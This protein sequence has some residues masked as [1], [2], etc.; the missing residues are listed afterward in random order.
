M[1]GK[2]KERFV[3]LDGLRGAA[4]FAVVTVHASSPTG[5]A[6]LPEAPLAVDF[7]FAL[8][9]FVLAYAY[10]ARFRN[11]LSVFEFMR[12]RWVRFWPMLLVAFILALAYILIGAA[13]R[14]GFH[15]SLNKYLASIVLGLAFL[16][17]PPGLS[18]DPR[19]AFPIVGPSYTMF[20]E[21]SVN[22]LFALLAA[23]LS[24][25]LLAAIV[26]LFAGLL[27]W[28][29]WEYGTI[30][31]GWLWE[32]FIGAFPRV[33][34]SFFSGA[35]VYELW[36]RWHPPSMPAWCSF[37]LLLAVF[38]VP[39]SGAWYELIAV[40]AFFPALILFSAGAHVTGRFEWTCLKIGA[41]SYGFY[42][43]HVPITRF[44]ESIVPYFGVTPEALDVWL[45]LLVVA[46]TG[47]ITIL[48]TRFY[49]RP[50]LRIF[51]RLVG[52]R[53]ATTP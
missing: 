16:P 14:G 28:S 53:T 38:V 48:L 21:L 36:R 39:A 5:K 45:V 12:A 8:S 41:L 34:F 31:Q 17:V 15:A 4:A 19:V 35:L 7:F 13:M 33:G 1:R 11:G 9:G 10:G 20:L 51:R 44:V 50:F 29:A 25:S 30:V 23:R 49:E 47:V 40:F 22:L 42:I 2:D 24:R 37:V 6:L 52:A 46:I 32:G 18:T 27:I 43:I 26:V 3:V